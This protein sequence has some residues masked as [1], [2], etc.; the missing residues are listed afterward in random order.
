MTEETRQTDDDLWD[1]ADVARYLKVSEA[2]V[3]NRIRDGEMP[4]RRVGGLIRFVPD[5][6]RRWVSTQPAA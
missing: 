2:T 3:R 5:E 6:V 1:V 4:F